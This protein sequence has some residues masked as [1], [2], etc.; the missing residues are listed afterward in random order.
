[1]QH[2]PSARI[3]VVEDDPSTADY[4]THVLEAMGGY[5][6][7]HYPSPTDALEALRKTR[8]D[9]IVT[10]VMLPGIDGVEFLKR[11]RALQPTLPVIMMTAYATVDVAIE[12]VQLHAAGFLRKPFA[13]GELLDRLAAELANR[14]NVTQRVLAIGAHPDDVEI[15]AGATLAAHARSGD[16]IAIGI[17]TRGVQGGDGETRILE[18]EAAARLLGADLHIGDLEDTR[19]PEGNPAVTFI[20]ELVATHQPTVVY[21]HS[22]NDVHQDHRNTHRATLVAARRV[23]ALYCYQSP[24][25]TVGFAPTRFLSVDDHLATKLELVA[26]HSSQATRRSY[27]DPDLISATGRYWGRFGES[28]YAEAFEVVRERASQRGAHHVAA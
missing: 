27:M 25:A 24:S 14:H 3:V 19:I 16:E 20:E 22:I 18:A 1:M 11:V 10:D 8:C 7:D 5:T 2:L 21:V 9:G 12:A 13:A 26:A 4:V 17:L 15:G 28:T 6:V 23:P